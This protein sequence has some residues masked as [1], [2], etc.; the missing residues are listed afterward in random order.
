M[1]PDLPTLYDEPFAD[2]SQIP[3]YLVSKLARQHVTVALSGDGGDELFA[4]YRRYARGLSIHQNISGVPAPLRRPLGAAFSLVPTGLL[5]P[6]S[7]GRLELLSEI[8]KEPRAELLYRDMISHWRRPE[9]VV[10]NSRDPATVLS[11]PGQWPVLPDFLHFMMYADLLTYLPDDVLAKVDRA[12]MGV[13]LEAR[14]PLL[15]HRLAEFAWRL[16]GEQKRRNGQGKWILRQVL[17]RYVPR[18]LIDRPKKGFG[19]PIDAWLRGPLREWA[20][21]L[22]SE[23]RLQGEGGYFHAGMVRKRWQERISEGAKDWSHGLWTVLMFGSCGKCGKEMNQIA[24]LLLQQYLFGI[25]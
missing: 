19:V 1:I 22:L 12:S 15:D 4:G 5:P 9:Q 18:P 3:T 11:D 25:N 16:P 24:F 14:V 13:S 21:E 23:R 17:D 8:L 20:E 7:A 10:I 2:S 6:Q